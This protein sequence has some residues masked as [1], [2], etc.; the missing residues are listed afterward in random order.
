MNTPQW[1]EALAISNGTWD[2]RADSIGDAF[3]APDPYLVVV[4][5][6]GQYDQSVVDEAMRATRELCGFWW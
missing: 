1:S 3:K 5:W 6:N 4:R 2:G